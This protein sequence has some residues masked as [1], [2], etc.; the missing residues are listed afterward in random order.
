M[1]SQLSLPFTPQT[2]KKA[3]AVEMADPI[4]PAE[5]EPAPLLGPGGG[6][7][8]V[9]GNGIGGGIGNGVEEP[10]PDP[11][12]DPLA[13]PAAPR[14]APGPEPEAQ[15]TGQGIQEGEWDGIP[16]SQ[17]APVKAKPKPIGH[18][19]S[20]LNV[21]QGNTTNS[22][23]SVDTT[24]PLEVPEVEVEHGEKKW[25]MDIRSIVGDAMAF[26]AHTGQ[27]GDAEQAVAAEGAEK[28]VSKRSGAGLARS[29]GSRWARL[30]EGAVSMTA[31]GV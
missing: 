30:A 16:E 17:G 13:G 21:V 19:G 28:I 4:V 8:G 1:Q 18:L 10:G 31:Q 26:L 9:E 29:W 20:N 7:E 24:D 14:A 6:G 25:A 5:P 3:A 23:D 15:G 2:V 27:G 12:P 11:R 22:T